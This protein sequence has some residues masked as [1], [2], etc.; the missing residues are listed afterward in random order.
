VR[1]DAEDALV[2]GADGEN[3][4]VNRKTFE[5]IYEP[6][7]SKGYGQDGPYRKIGGEILAVRLDGP[8]RIDLSGGRGVLTGQSGDWLVDYGAGDLAIVAADVFLSS[9]KLDPS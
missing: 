2:S 3:W 7:G 6:V 5:R 8:R 4:P 9:Y 1:Y